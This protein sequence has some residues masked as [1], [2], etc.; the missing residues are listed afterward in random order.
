MNMMVLFEHPLNEKMR[1][2][3]R[4]E[5]LLRQLDNCR[6]VTDHLSALNLFR[7]ATELLDVFERA[8]LR[9]EIL[10]ELDRQQYKLNAWHNVPGVDSNSNVVDMLRGDLKEQ[11]GILMSAPRIGQLLREERLINLVRQRL[12]IPGGCCSFDLPSLHIWLHLPQR[13]RD[14]Q[15]DM[16]LASLA[17]VR[18]TLALVLK[19]IRQSGVFRSQT[20]INGFY[21]NTA[22][23]TDLLRLQLTLENSL[24][25]QISGYKNRYAIRFLPLDS[26]QGEVPAQM[27]FMLACC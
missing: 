6:I 24:Y 19:L 4:I 26:E 9:T 16:W 1:T 8:E 11:Y 10:K 2:W 14:K 3:L 15:V 5:L 25:P 20:S 22:E 23:G 13:V 7:S 12:N 27:D 18:T 21:Q 17:P